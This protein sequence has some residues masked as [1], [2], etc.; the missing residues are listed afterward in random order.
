MDST[1]NILIVG[2]GG[3]GVVKA[4]E[5]LSGALVRHGFDVKQSEVHGMSQRGGSVT[6]EVRFGREVQSPLMPYAEADFVLALD[7]AEGRRAA[8]RLRPGT[9]RLVDVPPDLMARSADPRNRNMLALG[10]LSRWL[11][12]DEETWLQAIRH[13]MPARSVEENIAAFRAGRAYD[14][15]AASS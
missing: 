9:G 2:V 14:A 4:G 12:L 3:Q 8:P 6:S 7:D 11:A 15:P 10:R 13:A 5:A 1:V